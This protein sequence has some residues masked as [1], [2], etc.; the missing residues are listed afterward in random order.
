VQHAFGVARLVLSRH[1]IF[2]VIKQ[3]RAC[4]AVEW[5]QAICAGLHLVQHVLGDIG[6]RVSNQRIA[7]FD[8]PGQVFLGRVQNL[9]QH[10][11]GQL[12]SDHL[13]RLKL[14]HLQRLIQDRAA[15][16]TYLVFEPGHNGAREHFANLHT[17]AHVL[18]RVH[19]LKGAPGQVF[20]IGLVPMRMPRAD[21]IS[22]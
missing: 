20:L 11:H 16:R 7:L 12:A 2:R 5:H 3:V 13:G 1:Q 22:L 10:Q 4:G 15:Q 18:G 9:A 14:S 8:Q 21:D 17:G 6:V 19:L